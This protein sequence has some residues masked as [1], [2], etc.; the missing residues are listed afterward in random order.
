MKITQLT[1]LAEIQ[2]KALLNNGDDD[3]DDDYEQ[4]WRIW[5]GPPA[6][7]VTMEKNLGIVLVEWI[8]QSNASLTDFLFTPLRF[9]CMGCSNV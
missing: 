7:F 2:L 9:K 8:A 5:W 3:D 1:P 4:Q 6:Q